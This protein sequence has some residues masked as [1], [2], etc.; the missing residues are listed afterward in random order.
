MVIDLENFFQPEAVENAVANS[1]LLKKINPNPSKILS[2]IRGLTINC[3]VGAREDSSINF[4]FSESVESLTPDCPAAGDGS[5]HQSGA[6]LDEFNEWKVTVNKNQISMQGKLSP[7]GL[8]KILGILSIGSIVS[9]AD[10]GTVAS[11]SEPSVPADPDAKPIDNEKNRMRL[12]TQRY[13]RNVTNALDQVQKGVGKASPEQSAL[14]S[15]N[16]APESSRF[17]FAV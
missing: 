13:F 5:T 14:W 1:P 11:E 3:R 8:G 17:P 12:A 6:M 10:V 7:A 4:D 15:T 9:Q 16:T 2:G